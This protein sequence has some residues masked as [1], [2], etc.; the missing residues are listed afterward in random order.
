VTP[1]PTHPSAPGAGADPVIDLAS[2]FRAEHGRVV[3]S[4][5]RRFGDLDIAEDA[6]GEALLVAAE[7]WPTEG[8]PP[9]PGGWLTTV[10]ANK[11][12]DRIRREKRR[13][14][15]YA[16]V[17]RMDDRLSGDR[18]EPTGPVE[19]DRLRLVFT[20]CH[21]AL[22]PENRVALTLR[23][24][25]G[26]TVAE[27]A[28]GFLVPET[29]MAQ[30]IT[31]SKQ[32]IKAAHIPYRIPRTEDLPERMAGVL[33]VLYLVFNEGYLG[34][35]GEALRTDLTAEALRLTR[36]LREMVAATPSLGRQPEVDGLLALM[37]LVDSR[38][39]ARV[40][41]GI[42]V[43][44]DEQ[45]R[46]LWDAAMI[47]EGHQL[48]RACLALNRPGPYQL[49]AAINAVHTDAI[50][51]SMTEWSQVVQLFDQLLAISRSPVVALNRAVAVAEVDGPEVALALVEPL[52]LSSYHAWHATRADL[53]RRLQ[54]WDQARD[55]Y[56]RA[57][58]LAGND[59]ERGF[60]RGRRDHLPS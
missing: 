56:D 60:L 58:E 31:R 15:K 13:Q 49:Q 55:A 46:T 59:A 3:A 11:A 47:D 50:D 54:R 38:A 19:D 12:L 32:K 8:M 4:L 5:A 2:V 7:R 17:A 22:A 42:L 25:G 48:V 28:A 1:D 29:T 9:N 6:T 52:E 10:A 53:L 21:P 44:L 26:L 16:E 27:I 34:S 37:L 14:D 36:Q 35:S 43:P 23:M 51:S 57:I 24:L 41:D 40:H 30:R 18:P 45:D 33:A 20:C 39:Q